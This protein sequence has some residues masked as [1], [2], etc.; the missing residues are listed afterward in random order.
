MCPAGQIEVPVA[1]SEPALLSTGQAVPLL[2]SGIDN[3]NLVLNFFHARR[4]RRIML[5]ELF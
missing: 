1:L 5:R 3:G 4:S 2:T